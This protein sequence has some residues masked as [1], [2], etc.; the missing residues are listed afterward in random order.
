[1][2]ERLLCKETGKNRN[3]SGKLELNTIPGNPLKRIEIV[4]NYLHYSF[5]S[6]TVLLSRGIQDFCEI[7]SEK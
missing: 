1:V 3:G 7:F 2:A 5:T 4:I 6:Q